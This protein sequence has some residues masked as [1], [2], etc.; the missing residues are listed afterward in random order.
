MELRRRKISYSDWIR[1]Q[2]KELWRAQKFRMRH[3]MQTADGNETQVEARLLQGA[4]SNFDFTLFVQER[5][6]LAKNAKRLIADYFARHPEVSIVYGDEDLL[7]NGKRTNPWFKPCWSPDTY[8]HQFYLGSV[9][10]VRKELATDAGFPLERYS[11]SNV[12]EIRL[13]MD[14]MAA[15]AGGFSIG[16]ACATPCEDGLGAT[17]HGI[18]AIEAMLFHANDRA[19]WEEYLSSKES[20]ALYGAT[21]PKMDGTKISVIIPSKDNPEVLK[22]CLASLSKASALDIS[23]EII[24]VDNGSAPEVRKCIECFPEIATYLYEPAEFNF[25]HMCNRGAEAATGDVLLFLNDDCEMPEEDWLFTLVQQAKTRYVGA[26][27]MKL[28]YPKAEGQKDGIIQHDGIVN[29]SVG[30]V[31]KLQYLE[32]GKR[33]YFDWNRIDGNRVAVTAACLMVTAEKFH[34]VGGFCEE[35]RVAYNDVALCFSLLEAGYENVVVNSHAATHYESLSRG[36]DETPEKQERLTR[37]RELLYRLH[38][39]FLGKDPYYPMGLNREGLDSRIVPAYQGDRNVLQAPAWEKCQFRP[40]ELRKDDCLMARAETTGPDRIQGYGVVLGDDNACY[41]KYLFLIPVEKSIT[42][43][44]SEAQAAKSASAEKD[45]LENNGLE[46]RTPENHGQEVCGANGAID[47]PESVD[48]SITGFC[49]K[50]NRNYR[51]DLEENLPDQRNVALGGFCISRAGEMLPAGTYR[52]A[53]MAKRKVGR[54]FLW[55]DTGKFLTV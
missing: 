48:S 35:L 18:G 22:R 53:V 13:K 6:V 32:D 27:G 26:V 46:I 47:L 36:S 3:A 24:V 34:A 5:G 42:H 55:N 23:T 20:D 37:E 28:Y 54:L 7:E 51:Q 33:F 1:A 25:S 8:R 49:M 45:G 17:A 41:E 15:D 43:R 50:A 44:N 38:P 9:I 19:V 30:P 12:N 21:V 14:R 16:T 39:A 40:D 29:L 10:A 52:V 31:H 11:F 2:E 4:S